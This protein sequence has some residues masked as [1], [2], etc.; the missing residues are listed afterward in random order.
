MNKDLI[1]MNLVRAHDKFFN[2]LISD[3]QLPRRNLAV[4][5]SLALNGP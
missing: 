3:G 4:T 2:C 5:S 1:P